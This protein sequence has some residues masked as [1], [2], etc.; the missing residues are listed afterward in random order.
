MNFGNQL[1]YG[2][3]MSFG[4]QLPNG[5]QMSFGNQLPNGNQMSF[6]NQLPNGNQMG[7]GNQL[8]YMGQQNQGGWYD[9]TRWAAAPAGSYYSSGQAQAPAASPSRLSASAAKTDEER[10]VDAAVVTVDAN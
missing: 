3:Q 2:N 8:P 7:Y 5:N 1:P 10:N 4:N 6:G 9:A